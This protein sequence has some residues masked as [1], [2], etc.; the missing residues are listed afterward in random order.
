MPRE[1]KV[2]E[3]AQSSAFLADPIPFPEGGNSLF[4]A[5]PQHG[6]CLHTAELWGGEGGFKFGAR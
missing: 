3:G 5:Y 1:V 4:V 6:L 2:G